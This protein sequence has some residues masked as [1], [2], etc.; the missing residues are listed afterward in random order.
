MS[1]HTA[2]ERGI[3]NFG[4]PAR[5]LSIT[6]RKAF[7]GVVLEK[8]VANPDNGAVPVFQNA[9]PES[10]MAV[11]RN[12]P[13]PFW[14]LFWSFY[15]TTPARFGGRHARSTKRPRQIRRSLCPFYKTAPARF[16]G[17]QF[18]STMHPVVRQM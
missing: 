14:R 10:G 13:G 11:L 1:I 5:A 6:T 15:R 18:C 2:Y 17:R 9:L 8:L 16:G 3:T 4:H 12:G 7:S